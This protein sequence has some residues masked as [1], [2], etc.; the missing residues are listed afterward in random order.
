MG[1]FTA[2]E[3]AV[4]EAQLQLEDGGWEPTAADLLLTRQT[5]VALDGAVGPADVQES[6]PRIERLAGLREALA[7]LALAV[8]RIHGHLAWFLAQCASELAPVLHWRALP[9]PDGRAFGAVLP[10]TDQLADAERA[11]RL[12]AAM[13]ARTGGS[14]KPDS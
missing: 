11:V 4:L 2:I 14:G 1:M 3:Q 6:L 8:A 7:G 10:T 5:A 13:L 9:A 12:L